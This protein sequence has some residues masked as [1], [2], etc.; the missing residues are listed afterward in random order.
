MELKFKNRE[1]INLKKVMIY[2]NDGTGKS[3]YAET[4]SREHQL[5]PVVIDIDDTNYTNLPILDLNFKTDI[6]TYNQ[7]KNVINEIANEDEFDT[8]ILDGV[9]SLLEMLVSKAKGLKKYSDRAERFQD[10]LRTLLSSGKNIIFIGQSDMEVIYN[11]EFQSNKSIIKVNSIVNEKYL[12]YKKDGYSV[13]CVKNRTLPNKPYKDH[14]QQEKP[15]KAEPVLPRK[16]TPKPQSNN[17]FQI[18]DPEPLRTIVNKVIRILRNEGRKPIR[19]NIWIKAMECCKEGRIKPEYK[20]D[21]QEFIMT[22]CPE[23]LE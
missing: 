23:E 13:K 22:H 19:K 14:K 12:C 7:I 11:E 21:L 5:K 3:T 17:D 6:F 20:D 8:I 10:I 18:P 2:G 1:K 16:E 4:Y 9:T 15:V